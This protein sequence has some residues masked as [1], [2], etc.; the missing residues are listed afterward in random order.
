MFVLRSGELEWGV[1]LLLESISVLVVSMLLFV[2]FLN[3]VWVVLLL[4]VF[5][6]KLLFV[7]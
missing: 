2:W 4:I 3:Y 6:L 7:L 1:K 5:E